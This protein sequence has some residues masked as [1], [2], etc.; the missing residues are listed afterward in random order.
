M[1]FGVKKGNKVVA[2]PRL[3][4]YG[5]HVDDHQL[6]LLRQFDDL[7]IIC[8]CYDTEQLEQCYQS[9]E[10]MTFRPYVSNTQVIIESIEDYLRTLE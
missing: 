8:A 4:K 10:H 1:P 7:G 5:E 6:Q 3:A 2:V 9:L